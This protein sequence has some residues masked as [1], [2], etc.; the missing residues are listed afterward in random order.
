M[1]LGNLREYQV[2]ASQLI[3]ERKKALLA[4][5][6]GT[7]KEQPVSEPVLTPTGWRAI[8]DLTIGDMVIGSDGLP[9]KVTGVFPQGIK[10][11]Y[12][13]TT[14]WGSATRA[15][16]DHLWKVFTVN[17]KRRG[18]SRVLSTKDMLE[19]GLQYPSGQRKFSLPMC[20]PV[21][22]SP[23]P[24][25]LDAYTLGLLLGDGSF[26]HGV[27]F[28]TADKELL[29]AL[30]RGVPETCYIQPVFGYDYRVNSTLH[31]N[32][33]I[34]IV[35]SLGMWMHMSYEKFIPEVYL[36]ASVFD[37]LSL[38]QA[39]MDTD[40]Y[41]DPR[42]GVLEFTS[43]SKRLVEGIQE[44]IRS[45]GGTSSMRQKIV[46]EEQRPVWRLSFCLPAGM[47]PFRLTRKLVNVKER[48]KY[49]ASN[50]ID[51]IVL[52]GQE[53]SVCISVAANDHL[54]ITN[55]YLVTH[56]TIV[57]LHAIEKLREEGKVKCAVL[58]MSSSLTKQ[59]EQRISQFTDSS[60][61]LIDG[62]ISPK[63]RSTV[64]EE[65]LSQPPDYLIIGIRQ[66][67]SEFQ[68]LQL[69]NPDLVLVDEV[70]S[71]KN[72]GSQQSKTIKKLKSTYRIGLT[73][74]PIENGKAEELFSIM[75]WIDPD[76][77]GSW[78]S[79]E[80][81]Y[82]NRNSFNIIESYKNMPELNRILMTACISK[83]RT[84]PGVA[85]FMPTVE[86][87]NCYI[88]MDEETHVLYR[89]IAR[90]LLHALYRNGQSST[91]DI[92]GYYEGRGSS[93][94]GSDLG[95][96]GSRLLAASLLLDSPVI[97]RASG[98]AYNDPADPRG[99]L[100]A[101]TLS[102]S[103]RGLPEG[104]QGVKLE[105]CVELA[106]GYLE[107]NPEHKVIIFTRF[108]GMLPLLTEGLSKYGSVQFHGGLNGRQRGEA[109]QRFTD[110]PDIRLFISSDAGGYGVDLHSAS[111]L[112]N[113]D[114]P[115]SSGALKQRNG[116]HVRA[117][118]YFRNV[119]I[120]NLLIKNSVEEYQLSRLNYKSKVAQVILT[121]KGH[122]FDG[123]ITNDAKSL[124]KFLEDYLGDQ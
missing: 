124:T 102:D 28:T 70:T 74:E 90:E 5:D 123:T 69:I 40:G 27:K 98:D 63:K 95:P 93:T 48:S 14:K 117:S 59:W 96:I 61:K 3:T 43:T 25:P 8:G 51:S 77:F 71:I 41:V 15:G 13:I 29:E 1:F 81:S 45:L 73:A 65:C 121:G 86:E 44:L 78:Q 52:E 60:V 76:L 35:K 103:L 110:D 99:S 115:M 87:Y 53:E 4:L 85:E 118:S 6:L 72:F 9:T 38:I 120:D 92:A 20:S 104:F 11:V 18:T 36:R 79:F 39:L 56:N 91:Q 50:I 100:Y 7:G 49:S 30:S 108:R 84:D 21:Q 33:L 54:Y 114:L 32:P 19:Q 83:R 109:I 55:D 23:V 82:I 31:G 12:R 62:S 107:E 42:S 68:S 34:D 112:I 26:R 22:Y 94:S 101:S 64:L 47:K 10:D 24:L 2:E 89:Q 88:E 75:E 111:H 16:A 57:S 67:I 105:A 66:V 116:R 106:E 119:Y 37:R 58:I 97:L 122:S 113:Y 46:P 80:R 17:D